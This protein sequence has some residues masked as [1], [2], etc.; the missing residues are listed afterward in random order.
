MQSHQFDLV[1]TRPLMW[2]PILMALNWHT[3][4]PDNLAGYSNQAVDKALDSGD[5]A[6]A[7]AALREDPP[8]AFVCTHEKLVV[9]DARIKN[10]ML[11][12][13]EILETLPQWEVAQ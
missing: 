9:V 5:W 13:W 10:P 3:G 8:A 6:A 2:P 7:Q 1:L 12:P 4:S 11:G